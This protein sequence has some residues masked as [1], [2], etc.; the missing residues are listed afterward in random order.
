[1]SVKYKGHGNQYRR[2]HVEIVNKYCGMAFDHGHPKG[3]P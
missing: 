1:M 2:Q 3:Y